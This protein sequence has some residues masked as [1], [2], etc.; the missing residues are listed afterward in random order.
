MFGYALH[1]MTVIMFNVQGWKSAFWRVFYI[2]LIG[3]TDFA[4]SSICVNINSYY[5]LINIM[6]LMY[7]F[8][9]YLVAIYTGKD[10]HTS[11]LLLCVF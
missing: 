1:F 4:L 9:L 11:N 7:T 10:F 8:V 3:L 6:T 2:V 5:L